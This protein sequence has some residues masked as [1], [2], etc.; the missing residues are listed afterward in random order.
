M[1]LDKFLVETGVWSRSQVKSLLKKKAILVNQEVETSPKVQINEHKD[2]VT[3]LGKPLTY[4][5]FVYYILNKPAGFLSA[6]KDRAQATV[7]DL[8]DETARQKDVFPVGRLDKDTRGLLLLTNNGQLAHDLLSPKK[9]VTKE[10]LAKVAGIMTDAD[11]D[12]FAKGISLKDHQCLP[13]KLEVLDKDLSQE[14]CVVSI[15]IQ[16]GKFHQVKRMVA[17]CGKEVLEL[18]RLSMGPLRLDPGLAEGDFR[19]LTSDELQSLEPYCQSL[20]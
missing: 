6:T 14:T 2:V 20:L 9:H 11:K 18:Q 7:I 17:A 3:Y 13:A 19:R 4:E 5:A 1:R 8:L 15:T 10:Y 16:E 12:D